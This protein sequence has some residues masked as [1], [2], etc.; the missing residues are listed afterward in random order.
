MIWGR[1]AIE[2]TAGAMLCLLAGCSSTSSGGDGAVDM[3]TT[4]GGMC[5]A[6]IPA[7]QECNDVQAMGAAITPTC[8]SATM[9]VG[10]GGTIVDGTYELTSNTYY[11]GC[12][13]LPISE[14]VVISGDCLE[15]ATGTPFRITASG[16]FTVAGASLMATSACFH[17]DVDGATT[18]RSGP[19]SNTT[20][21]ATPTSLTLFNPGSTDGGSTS[22]TV[23]VFTRR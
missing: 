21:S 2:R 14:T 9:P 23:A 22:S 3:T 19:S 4:T 6:G 18:T 15:I 1:R 5:G 10:T 20:F 8:V 17:I 11:K 7:G 16:T 12:E 13:T